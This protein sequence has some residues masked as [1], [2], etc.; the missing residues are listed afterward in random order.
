MFSYPRLISLFTR[1]YR[2]RGCSDLKDVNADSVQGPDPHDLL[3]VSR[4]RPQA[5]LRMINDWG[6]IP[7]LFELL[8]RELGR[9]VMQSFVPF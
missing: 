9:R 4:N 3:L 7:K 1:Q 8:L 6:W 2:P 5:R